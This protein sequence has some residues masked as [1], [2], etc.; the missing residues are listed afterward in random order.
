M[1]RSSRE[2]AEGTRRLIREAA[3]EIFSEKGY[4]LTTFSDIAT[5]IKRT[6]GAVYGHYKCK[7]D[8]L[9]D[10]I[11]GE[12]EDFAPM[13]PVESVTLDQIRGRLV[14]WTRLIMG[15]ERRR[16]FAVFA[17]SRVEWSSAL[18]AELDQKLPAGL[19]EPL[20]LLEERI[21]SLKTRCLVQAEI[22]AGE[23]ATWVRS[24]FFGTLRSVLLEEVQGLDAVHAMDTGLK[25]IFDAVAVK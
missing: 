21:E 7:V 17:M 18:K 1:P 2:E 19:N 8:L 6:K 5:R 11:V 3:L 12:H 14:E 25:L 22:V 15:D 9:A 24:I 16:R 20:S 13:Y 23:L 10:L 4:A